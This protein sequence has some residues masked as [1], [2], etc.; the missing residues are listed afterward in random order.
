MKVVKNTDQYTVYQ[1]RSGR[2]AVQSN[3]GTPINQEDKVKILLAEGLIAAPAEKA[4]EPAPVVEEVAE[5]SAEESTEE[6]AAEEPSE[7]K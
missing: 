5:E 4:P 2:Y 1:K 7:D 3:K 6:A